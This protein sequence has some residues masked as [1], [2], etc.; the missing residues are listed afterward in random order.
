MKKNKLFY[1][2]LFHIQAG[3]NMSAD[4]MVVTGNRIAAV[5]NGLEKDSDFKSFEKINL[6][7]RTVIPGFIDSHTH[8]YFYAMSL[9]SVKLDGLKSIEESLAAV[10]KHVAGLGRN[11][12]VVGDG[13]SPDRW[14]K[15]VL[16][17][18]YM[19]DKLTGGRPAAI[20][21][22]DQHIMWVNSRALEMAAINQKTPDPAGGKIDRLANNE[23]SGILREMPAYFPV[24]KLIKGPAQAK[25][26]G[27][28]REARKI[29]YSKGVTGVHS[30]DGR[31]AL[32]F[33]DNLARKK[34]LGLRINY[35][36]PAAML[37]ELRR[38]KIK[39]GYGDDYFRVSGIKIF[40]DGSLG[41]QTALCFNK[42]IGS[43]NNYG[44][45]T[46]SKEILLKHIKNAARLNLP[47]A[48]H[49]IGDKAIAN[50]LDCYEQAPAIPPNARRRIEHVQ[51]IR[52]SDIKRLKALDVVASMQPSHCPSDVK[53]TEKYW[54]KRG[55][56]CYIFKTLL[57]KKIPV[58][59]GSDLPIEPLDPIA[60]IDAAVN[61][62][63]TGIKRPFYPE[64][65]ISIAEA[66]Y[67][68]TASPAF[69]VGQEFERG[70][71]LPG[72]FADFIVLSENI[73]K[74]ARSRI[75]S[76]NVVAT[77]FDGKPVYRKKGISL[78]F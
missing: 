16:P 17:D 18:K 78:P 36:P 70:F 61:R 14:K 54:G 42:F 60:G 15:Y 23:P 7:G 26:E 53:L 32:P 77:F 75:K 52:R 64:E 34:R 19:L 59:F 76:V 28:F 38:S 2:G 6:R 66:V 57:D 37:P 47:T 20:Y 51:M 12:W 73:L 4:S 8:F 68:F 25:Q 43:K 33:F 9:G 10:K 27:L 13:F 56:N 49:A 3:D 67:G 1:N 62:K 63:A 55:R 58:T 44:V 35:Y 72:Y 41:S 39:L 29:A 48:I 22:K 5:G 46:N 30:F 45:E 71:L 24:L 40:S 65:G 11:D 21:S 74:V 31:E 50:V 69:T